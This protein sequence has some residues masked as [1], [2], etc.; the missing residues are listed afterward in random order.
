MFFSLVRCGNCAGFSQCQSVNSQWYSRAHSS[1]SCRLV[2][3]LWFVRER[4]RNH[5]TNILY[6][7]FPRINILKC[8]I[9]PPVFLAIRGIF[10][11]L[12]VNA[13]IRLTVKEE[14]PSSTVRCSTMNTSHRVQ[15]VRD[16]TNF[17]SRNAFDMLHEDS[18]KTALDSP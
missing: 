3:Y 9:I 16:K 11:N 10:I 13:I 5:C 1:V 18:Y 7:S 17:I 4:H 15:S 8:W 2:A 12:W 14:I 6:L